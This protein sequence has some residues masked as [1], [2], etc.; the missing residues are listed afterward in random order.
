MA[1]LHA[2]GRRN[3]SVVLYFDLPNASVLVPVDADKS[4]S[5]AVVP[6]PR[7]QATSDL[8]RGSRVAKD[9]AQIGIVAR[10]VE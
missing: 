6:T 5:S 10:M 1:Q 8:F 9:R 2:R 3:T 4:E 7:E